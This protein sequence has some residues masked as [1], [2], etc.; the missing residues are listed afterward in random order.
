MSCVQAT[1]TIVLHSTNLNVDPKNVVITNKR[2]SAMP[3]SKVSYN[4]EKQFMYVK[5]TDQFKV[6]SIYTLTI[7]F[8][9]NI[10]DD[11]VGYYRSSYVDEETHKT[12]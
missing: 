3:V 4:I 8:M 12:K 1:D 11:L 10:T 7:P 6:G 9:G 5:S 2:G